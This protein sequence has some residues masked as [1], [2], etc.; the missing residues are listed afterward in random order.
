[1]ALGH[2]GPRWHDGPRWHLVYDGTMAKMALTFA[3]HQF[4]KIPTLPTV[5]VSLVLGVIDG[6][7][8][9]TEGGSA[10]CSIVWVNNPKVVPVFAADGAEVRDR[11]H[12]ADGP[13][14]EEGPAVAEAAI[15]E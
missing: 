2:R 10:G 7:S 5:N 14:R 3:H 11:A 4:V 13:H 1:M 6:K 9:I 15:W 8:E 12:G